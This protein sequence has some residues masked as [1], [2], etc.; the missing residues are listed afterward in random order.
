ME[1][2][3]ILIEYVGDT[4]YCHLNNFKFLFTYVIHAYTAR[5]VNGV[6]LG[7]CSLSH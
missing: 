6:K 2:L 5:L 1:M 4:P 3:K 7:I